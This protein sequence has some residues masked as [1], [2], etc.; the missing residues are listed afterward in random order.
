MEIKL[1]ND[2]AKVIAVKG[3]ITCIELLHGIQ[4]WCM[5]SVSRYNELMTYKIIPVISSTTGFVDDSCKDGVCETCN[6]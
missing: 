5:S 2:N 4:E 6:E 3:D 1:I